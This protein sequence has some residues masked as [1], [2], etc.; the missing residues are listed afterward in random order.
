MFIRILLSVCLLLAMVIQDVSAADEEPLSFEFIK[1]PPGQLVA[2]DSYRLHVNCIG[3]GDITVLFEAG[4]GGSSLEWLPVQQG[5]SARVRSCAY[6]RAGYAW[7]DPS[8]YPRQAVQ[9]AHEANMMLSALGVDGP[10]L[11]VAHSFGGFVARLLAKQTSL[12]IVGMILID[13]SHEDQFS[14]MEEAGGKSVMPTSQSFVISNSHAPLNLPTDL[15]RKVQALSRM[16]KSYAATHGEMA[17]FRDSARQVKLHRSKVDF[18]VAVLLRGKDPFD[19][20]D[21]NSQAKNDIWRTLQSDL[22]A[23]SEKG[24][25]V[26]AERS[27]HH[28]HV[29]EPELVVKTI[30]GL[31]DDFEKN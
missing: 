22:V 20:A 9:I 29:D 31:I 19:E 1:H 6:D 10:L 11:L 2:F 30:E 3:E 14:K 26:V 25:S 15:R 7:S 21:K 17:A 27:G 16:R 4:L 12:P 24:F 28:V 23:L 13:S 5:L 18:P 8:P